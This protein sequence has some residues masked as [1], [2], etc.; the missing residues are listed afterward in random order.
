MSIV[1]LIDFTAILP[2]PGIFLTQIVDTNNTNMYLIH[3]L[4][5]N[6][7]KMVFPKVFFLKATTRIHYP[8]QQGEINCVDISNDFT[9]A[10]Y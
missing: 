6:I 9:T 2:T 3:F 4:S 1:V 8:L 5:E 7:I 10:C